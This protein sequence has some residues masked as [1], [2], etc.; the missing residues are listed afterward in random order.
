MQEWIKYSEVG[1]NNRLAMADK[2][3]HDLEYKSK[4]IKKEVTREK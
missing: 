1:L 3:I 2:R 4:D